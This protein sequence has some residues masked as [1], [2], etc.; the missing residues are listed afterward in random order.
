MDRNAVSALAIG[1]ISPKSIVDDTSVDVRKCPHL[2]DGALE[3]MVESQP[4]I[5]TDGREVVDRVLGLVE[6]IEVGGEAVDVPPPAVR[7]VGAEREERVVV[8]IVRREV[9]SV[10]EGQAVA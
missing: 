7:V 8:P 2:H 4:G 10:V 1:A 5:P 9:P 3:R 6:S